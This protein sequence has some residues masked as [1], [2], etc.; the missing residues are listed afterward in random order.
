MAATNPP[1]L[2]VAPLGSGG[3]VT[4]QVAEGV[5]DSQDTPLTSSNALGEYLHCSVAQKHTRCD[6]PGSFTCQIITHPPIWVDKLH[7]RGLWCAR[8]V[9]GSN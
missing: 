4:G 9:T 3:G 2:T 6:S 1:A 8:P 5:G 7:R